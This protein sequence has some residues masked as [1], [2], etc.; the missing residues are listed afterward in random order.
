MNFVSARH[1]LEF[2]ASFYS[3]LELLKIKYTFFRKGGGE[4]V[5][6]WPVGPGEGGGGFLWSK[7]GTIVHLGSK[8]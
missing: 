8:T 4:S 7:F 5:A 2:H 6:W 1:N 3:K